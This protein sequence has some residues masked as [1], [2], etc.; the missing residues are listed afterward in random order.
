MNVQMAIKP[1][2][3]N[4]TMRD[5]VPLLNSLVHIQKHLIVAGDRALARTPHASHLDG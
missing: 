5:L 2:A 4:S 1:I 3:L